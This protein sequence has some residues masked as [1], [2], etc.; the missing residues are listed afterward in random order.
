V[1]PIAA[2]TMR[3]ASARTAATVVSLAVALAAPLVLTWQQVV[4][5]ASWAIGLGSLL[6]APVAGIVLA[7]YWVC[8]GGVIDRGALGESSS[9][10]VYH[11]WG[12]VNFRAVIAFLV[13]MAPDLISVAQGFDTLFG[14]SVAAAAKVGPA[15]CTAIESS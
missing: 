8:R 11:Y 6:V 12:G 3:G 1:G 5:V 15:S 9:S 14:G 7:D 2:L 4:A 10:G 13:G